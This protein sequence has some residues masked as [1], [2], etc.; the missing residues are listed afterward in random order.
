MLVVILYD[1]V[2]SDSLGGK[3]MEVKVRLDKNTLDVKFSKAWAFTQGTAGAYAFYSDAEYYIVTTE[4]ETSL[5]SIYCDVEYQTPI[6][7]LDSLHRT[8][9]L[10][11]NDRNYKYKII[12]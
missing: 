11:G 2:I 6:V 10:E 8:F 1:I 3:N 4:E 9:K 5:K 12:D 7:E